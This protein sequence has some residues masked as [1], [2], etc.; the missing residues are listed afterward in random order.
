MK[1]L[2]KK[3]PKLLIS[4]SEKIYPSFE[5]IDGRPYINLDRLSAPEIGL[6]LLYFKYP[7]R[8]ERQALI[9]AIKRHGHK[10]NVAEVATHRLKSLVDDE[11]G[12]WKLRGLGR[13]KAEA[14]LNGKDI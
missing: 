5:E 7:H 4:L 6:L 9:D 11:G 3:I 10:K 8:I 13:Q 1:G 14:F 12:A 2:N